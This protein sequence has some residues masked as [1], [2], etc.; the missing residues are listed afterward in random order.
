VAIDG[1]KFR[2]V[3][4]KGR[5]F[6]QRKLERQIKGLDEKIDKY[7]EELDEADEEE[8][9]VAKPTAEELREKLE[10]LKGRRARLGEIE[11]QLKKSDESQV[12]LTDADSRA[13]LAPAL[14][15]QVCPSAVG[16]LRS[17]ATMS[18]SASTRST[19]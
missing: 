5:N 12:S 15:V 14:Q 10:A 16:R 18:S 11:Q 4:S 8:K 2:A 3:N 9:D 19:S 7:L 17:L 1:S 6:T 13:T